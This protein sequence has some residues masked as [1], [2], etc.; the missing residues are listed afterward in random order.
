MSPGIR[1][2]DEGWWARRESAFAWPTYWHDVLDTHIADQ[3]N[4]FVKL[5]KLRK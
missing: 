2:D 3:E 1:R 4:G 5:T